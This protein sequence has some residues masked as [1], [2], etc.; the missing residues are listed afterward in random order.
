LSQSRSSGSGN[1]ASHNPVKPRTQ[2]AMRNDPC[3]FFSAHNGSSSAGL[4][5]LASSAPPHIETAHIAAQR[6]GN[7][8]PRTKCQHPPTASKPSA[9]CQSPG[10]PGL[11]SN[12]ARLPIAVMGLVLRC[13]SLT[14]SLN[15]SF[16]LNHSIETLA[17]W[18]SAW[19]VGFTPA[20]L[21]EWGCR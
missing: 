4:S 10:H 3:S 16:S 18:C 21:G 15:Y 12:G 19:A 14:F 9:A 13:R 11:T 1:F 2:Y 8:P 7:M 20:A 5:R 17:N 6:S